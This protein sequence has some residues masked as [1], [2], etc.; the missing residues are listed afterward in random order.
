GR[1]THEASGIDL[2]PLE[3]GIEHVLG[4]DDADALLGIALISGYPGMNALGDR[5]LDFRRAVRQVDHVYFSAWRHHRPDGAVAQAHDCGDHAAFLGLDD[6]R[7]F[8]LAAERQ[9]L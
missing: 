6:A 9:G 5:T 1:G 2:P 7:R 3:I 4:V 8:R